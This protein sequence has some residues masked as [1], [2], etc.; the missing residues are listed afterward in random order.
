M[1][2]IV[3]NEISQNYSY[4]NTDTNFCTVAFPITS[5]WGPGFFDPAAYFSDTEDDADGIAHMLDEV[6]WKH[7]PSTQEG[8]QSFIA[9][10][11]GAA[12]GYRLVNDYSYQQAVTLLCAGYDVLVCRI[13][14]GTLATGTLTQSEGNA[15]NFRAKYPGTFG[16]NI[17]ITIKKSSYFDKNA[18]EKENYKRTY[19]TLITYVIDS[20]GVKTSVETRSMV[21]NE[22]NATD[23]V[24]YYKEIVS[25]FYDITSI[26]GTI[27][28]NSAAATPK[29]TDPV[30][31]KAVNYVR[32]GAD[33]KSTRGTDYNDTLE[34]SAMD[35]EKIAKIRY[36]WA[37]NYVMTYG[38][39]DNTYTYPAGIKALVKNKDINEKRRL[40]AREWILSHLV[41]TKA[42]NEDNEVVGG[43]FDLL[44][45][46]LSY[47]PSRIYGAGFDDQDFTVY[48]SDVSK[49][50]DYIGS[51]SDNTC[52]LPISPL[53][54]KLMDVAYNSRCAVSYLDIP[55]CVFRKHVHI[56]DENNAE[57]IGYTQKLARVT[58][59]NA[60]FEVDDSLF[61][62]HSALFAPWGRFKYAG[63]S[64][65]HRACPSFFEL[66]IHR[67]Q[68]RNQADQSEWLLPSD[69]THNIKVLDLDYKV[70]KKLLDKWQKLDGASV[71]IIANI[72]GLGIT[73]W[74]N[75]TLYEVPVETYQALANLS[76]RWLVDA[77]KDVIYQVG[78]SVTF[79]YN[80][81]QAY[82]KMY[83]GTVPI[84]DHMVSAK[85]I[86][87]Y[88][89]KY[90][91]DLNQVDHVNANTVVGTVVISVY[92][93]INDINVDLV[94][95]PA[96]IGLDPADFA[97]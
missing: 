5:S 38:G 92:G 84:L 57:R 61:V 86:E 45:D 88:Y 72:P 94:A 2:Q 60:S 53:H 82:D 37:S 15:I 11:R 76:T 32:L 14:P 77:I 50:T 65:Y 13:C 46:K 80:N 7:F 24:P 85:A 3:V 73:N 52:K 75:S 62:T 97:S 30:Y 1:A 48:E 33:E 63:M 31:K 21:F 6:E 68:L 74:G 40:Y 79:Q 55:R 70:P 26:D 58:P 17:Q 87:D 81:Q 9:T 36:D 91:A 22:D 20:S 83:A 39:A 44:K 23:N 51:K 96:G 43:V 67:A 42:T 71:N 10:Y 95:I 34:D 4:R 16:N 66:L 59:N 54:L 64:S 29:W 41:G 47:N 19:W 89:V 56:E 49:L 25:N 78:L 69:R 90:N 27:Q 35:F 8:L 93:V 18:S 12:T 28:E